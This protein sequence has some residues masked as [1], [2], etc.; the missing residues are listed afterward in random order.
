MYN[1]E[2]ENEATAKAY[3][4]G[5]LQQLLSA[6]FAVLFWLLIGQG[7]M[8]LMGWGTDP[9]DQSG[10]KRSGLS[11]YVDHGTGVEYVGTRHGGL[12]LREGVGEDDFRSK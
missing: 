2:K 12:M 6:A 1:A 7:I 11:Y 8:N 9:T 3:T 5:A 4:K 10:W